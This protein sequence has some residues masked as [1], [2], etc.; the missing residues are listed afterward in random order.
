MKKYA[1]LYILD[2]IINHVYTE[3]IPDEKK[4][5]KNIFINICNM[6]AIV[7]VLCDVQLF[8]CNLLWPLCLMYVVKRTKYV[9]GDGRETD[10]SAALQD[11]PRKQKDWVRQSSDLAKE[12]HSPG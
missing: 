2:A 4:I 9:R 3:Y 1:L 12:I 6:Y 7:I 10:I 11:S 5:T 8:K